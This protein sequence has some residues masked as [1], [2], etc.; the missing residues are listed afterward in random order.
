MAKIV[1]LGGLL[2]GLLGLAV[3]GQAVGG[4]EEKSVPE[5]G[6]GV[7][8]STDRI[9]YAAGE[10]ITLKLRVFNRTKEAIGFHF[11]DAQRFDFILKDEKGDEV[12]RWSGGMMFAQMLGKEELGPGQEELV[13][14]ATCEEKL[15]PGTY[16]LTGV[17]VAQDNPMSGSISISVK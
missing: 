16:A 3:L 1:I 15:S 9:S 7:S 6:F 2:L 13:Y 17:L 10:P 12:W 14:S 5:S 11:R 8:V 4:A